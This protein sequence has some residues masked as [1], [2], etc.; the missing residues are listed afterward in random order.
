MKCFLWFHD[1]K[2]VKA[3]AFGYY[4]TEA[5]GNE[6][7]RCFKRKVKFHMSGRSV[8]PSTYEA[9]FNWMNKEEIR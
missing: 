2:P 1:W 7:Q 6:C 9:I 5:V 8:S 3:F 4:F